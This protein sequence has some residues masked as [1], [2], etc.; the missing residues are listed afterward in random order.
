MVP[1]LKNGLER[2]LWVEQIGAKLGLAFGETFRGP[3]TCLRFA[4][5]AFLAIRAF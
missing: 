1:D 4:I 3:Y 5:A 2:K